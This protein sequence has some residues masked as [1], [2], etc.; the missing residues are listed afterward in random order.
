MDFKWDNNQGPVE[1]DS[2][3]VQGAGQGW[4]SNTF[5]GFKRKRRVFA[6]EI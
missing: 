2:P 6:F 4:K 5:A 3:F 1:H